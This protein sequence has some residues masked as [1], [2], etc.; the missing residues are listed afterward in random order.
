MSY[1]D[2]HN[3]HKVMGQALKEL[4]FNATYYVQ[5]SMGLEGDFNKIHLSPEGRNKLNIAL[6][7]YTVWNP[8][9]GRYAIGWNS[10]KNS[11]KQAYDV[12]FIEIH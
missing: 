5:R 6:D 12:N 11:F 3:D 2:N 1:L 8:E 4:D 7:A 10:V 9:E